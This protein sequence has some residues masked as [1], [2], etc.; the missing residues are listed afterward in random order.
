MA[1][2]YPPE[3]P[4]DIRINPKYSGEAK[5]YDQLKKLPAE[6]TVFYGVELLSKPFYVESTLVPPLGEA[7]FIII[8]QDYGL[9][10]MEVKGGK[11]TVEN[12]N[13]QSTDRNNIAHKIK[14]PYV[15]SRENSYRVKRNLKQ[16][17]GIEINPLYAVILPDSY[18]PAQRF[19]MNGSH[20]ITVYRSDLASLKHRIDRIFLYWK[21]VYNEQRFGNNLSKSEVEEIIGLMAPSLDLGRLGTT[22][23]VSKPMPVRRKNKNFYKMLALVVAIAIVVIGFVAF[24]SR[25]TTIPKSATVITDNLNQPAIKGVDSIGTGYENQT[26]N[27]FSDSNQSDGTKTVTVS[28]PNSA[29]A[30]SATA[31]VIT[32]ENIGKFVTFSGKVIATYSDDGNIFVVVASNN[33]NEQVTVPIFKSLKYNGNSA[34]VGSRIAV[35]GE[36]YKFKNKLEVVPQRAQDITIGG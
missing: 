33:S 34:T 12:S 15:Q 19:S 9:I 32:E 24:G 10:T 16:Y 22:A 14:D 1:R 6:Y 28:Q 29:V 35:H 2:M 21:D 27:S 30:K 25:T 3:L 18:E 23:G 20:E 31:K 8:H 11:I 17:K 26:E 13:W 36:I 7:D 5:I 4:Q